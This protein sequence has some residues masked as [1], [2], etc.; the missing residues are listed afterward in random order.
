MTPERAVRFPAARVAAGQT[1]YVDINAV[2]GGDGSAE[3]PFRTIQGG[4]RALPTAT[5]SR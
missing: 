1:L 4:Q 5:A 2:P 3:H